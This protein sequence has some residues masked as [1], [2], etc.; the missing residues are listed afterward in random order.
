[1]LYP[2]LS[3]VTERVKVLTQLRHSD[4]IFPSDFDVSNHLTSQKELLLC[5]LNHDPN[6][7][8]SS[9]EL[10]D[11][12]HLPPV[13]EVE[14]QF[15]RKVD[16]AVRNPDSQSCRRILSGLFSQ[17]YSKPMDRTYNMDQ[18]L[19]CPSIVFGCPDVSVCVVG[20]CNNVLCCWDWSVVCCHR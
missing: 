8:P 14:A 13:Q 15:I 5:M 7:R 4:I 16:E 18:H 9:K 2:K 17:K 10:L 20:T 3:T 19:V 1:M 6:V 11:S 12:K